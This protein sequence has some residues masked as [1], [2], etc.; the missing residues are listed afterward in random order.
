MSIEILLTIATGVVASSLG[1]VIYDFINRKRK[2]EQGE[3]IEDRVKRL[4]KSLG[5]ATSLISNIENE[6]KARSALATQLQDDIDQYNKLVEVKK[7]EVE[8]IAQLLRGEL[9]KESRSSFWKGFAINFLFFVLGAG[10][11][12]GIN[13]L[14][15]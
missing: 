15:K 11:S 2:R 10:A 4:T 1:N 6:I 5:E 14:T 9:K 12:W 8:A 3:T 13:L 7:P